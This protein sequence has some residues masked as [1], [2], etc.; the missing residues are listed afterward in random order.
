MDQGGDSRKNFAL[1][2]SQAAGGGRGER[3]GVVVGAL[4]E[5]LAEALGVTSEDVDERNSLTE[6]GV[7]SLM[8]VEL[9]NWMR[10]GF[11]AAVAVFE[12][13][14]AGRSIRSVA[15]LVIESVEEGE[16]GNAEGESVEQQG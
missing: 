14:N 13:M 6:Y 11:G 1:L 10:K 16:N 15:R 8:A 2:F 7:D 3:E 12:M 9:R 5:K 4:Q